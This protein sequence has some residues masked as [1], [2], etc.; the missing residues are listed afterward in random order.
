MARTVLPSPELPP[1]LRPFPA[2]FPDTQG[3]W[4]KGVPKVIRI[5]DLS[6]AGEGKPQCSLSG[7]K[8][9]TMGWNK[10]Q[11]ESHRQGAWRIQAGANKIQG[12]MILV[13]LG[14]CWG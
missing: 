6:L 1:P 3:T 5:A 14:S 13:G 9:I 2:S 11:E 10:S 4:L 8:R 7:L 12:H